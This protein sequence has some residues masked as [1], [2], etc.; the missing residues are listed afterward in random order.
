MNCAINSASAEQSRIGR[1]Y[2][3]IDFE[4]RNIAADDVDL[5]EDSFQLR[6]GR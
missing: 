2:D 3:G 6:V 1:V 4:F 5:G